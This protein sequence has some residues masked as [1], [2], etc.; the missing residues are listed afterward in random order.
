M[1]DSI[2]VSA[3]LPVSARRLYE[4]WLDSDEHTAFTG[5]EATVDPA[6]GGGFTAWDGYIEGATEVLEPYRRIVQRWRTTEFPP[7]SP[8]SRLEVLLEPT[9]G[10][11]TITL[12]HTQIPEGQGQQYE[13]D[14]MEF[15]FEPIQRYFA[16]EK[17]S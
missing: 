2:R 4:A 14:W 17:A 9:Q 10:R 8:D 6:M 11:A 16:D 12:V 13:Q 15:Y 3:F 1:A 5:S 7:G